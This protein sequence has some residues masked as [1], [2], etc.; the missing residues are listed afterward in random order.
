MEISELQN[1]P[2]YEL[3]KMGQE[4]GIP[5]AHMRKKEYLMIAINSRTSVEEG[6]EKGGGILEIMPEGIGFLR[7][8][9]QMS[10]ND[11]YVSQAQLRRFDLRNGDMVFGQ[12]RPPR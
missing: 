2:L 3:R 6:I 12:I 5:N 7:E 11:I 4:L 1:K 9:Y 10:K 8:N